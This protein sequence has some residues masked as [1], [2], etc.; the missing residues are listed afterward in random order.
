MTLVA[1]HIKVC[2]HFHSFPLCLVGFQISQQ[3]DGRWNLWRVSSNV[4]VWSITRISSTVSETSH[5][6]A[7]QLYDCY[8]KRA[9]FTAKRFFLAE[10]STNLSV[11]CDVFLCFIQCKRP[12][13]PK[14]EGEKILSEVEKLCAKCQCHKKFAFFKVAENKFRVCKAFLKL[15]LWK[16]FVTGG[17]SCF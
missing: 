2:M 12:E 10:F 16:N 13:K 11:K 7:S 14:T 6:W 17:I 5:R 15:C 9:I 3:R 8:T 4:M 1:R